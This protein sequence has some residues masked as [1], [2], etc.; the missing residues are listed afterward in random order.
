M[1]M[2]LALG[3][4]ALSWA[5]FPIGPAGPESRRAPDRR[6]AL[7]HRFDRSGLGQLQLAWLRPAMLTTAAKEPE[8]E[9]TGDFL[10]AG[11]APAEHEL[12]LAFAADQWH[13]AAGSRHMDAR[14]G[15]A[16]RVAQRTAA[17]TRDWRSLDR[18]QGTHHDEASPAARAE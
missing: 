7:L 14:Q 2:F 3:L 6:Q 8:I 5:R 1:M 15:S 16:C 18:N 4:H 17:R 11:E 10:M 13:D 9:Q 12:P